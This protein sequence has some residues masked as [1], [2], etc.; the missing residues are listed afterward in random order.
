[1]GEKEQEFLKYLKRNPEES[2]A[3]FVQYLKIEAN[4]QEIREK[5]EYLQTLI[6]KA[7]DL[8]LKTI[9]DLRG[10]LQILDTE[11][12]RLWRRV[13]ENR[14][15]MDKNFKIWSQSLEEY[16]QLTYTI[17][18]KFTTLTQKNTDLTKEQLLEIKN[19]AR[20]IQQAVN[21]LETYSKIVEKWVD[22]EAIRLL[23][24]AESELERVKELKKQLERFQIPHS[25]DIEKIDHTWKKLG[26]GILN[27][28]EEKIGFFS[29]VYLALEDLMPILEVKREQELS[30]SRIK[31]LF[32]EIKNTYGKTSFHA[33]RRDISEEV[34]HVSSF[35]KERLTPTNLKLVLEEKN[36]QLEGNVLEL[37]RPEFKSIGYLRYEDLEKRGNRWK[38]NDKKI[39]KNVKYLSVPCT[40][41]TDDLMGKKKNIGEFQYN[42]EFHHFLPKIGYS[43]FLLRKDREGNFTPSERLVRKIL[44]TFREREEISGKVGIRIKEEIDD[45]EE[46]VWRLKMAVINGLEGADI[47]ES[48]ALKPKYLFLFCLKYGIPIL[49]TEL[50]QSYF[51]IVQSLKL[52]LPEEAINPPP[53]YGKLD[54]AELKQFL[55]P[56]CWEILGLRLTDQVKVRCTPKKSKSEL[57]QMLQR[58]KRDTERVEEIVSES[59][60]NRRLIQILLLTRRVRNVS[61]YREILTS[62]GKKDIDY[63]TVEEKMMTDSEERIYKRAILKVLK[64]KIEWE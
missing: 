11:V 8:P 21:E 55:P 18:D 40:V 56:E 20:T 60:D 53:L 51:D 28:N 1:M 15:A 49:F 4:S 37:L 17:K 35:S 57:I 50:I 46:A 45:P 44:A 10:D 26:E 38:I 41:K 64:Q 7:R 25:V 33:F 9:M 27:Q 52:R 5:A 29:D 22:N 39:I 61:D 59:Q 13:K 62:L 3:G 19:L 42:I 36:I 34:K 31:D 23:S 6:D 14:N 2:K 32:E 54:L 16:E 30:E 48:E 12:D 63:R 43:Y 24:E 58:K 47:G